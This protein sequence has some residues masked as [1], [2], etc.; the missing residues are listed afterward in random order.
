MKR[1]RLQYCLVLVLAMSNLALLAQNPFDAARLLT[2]SSAKIHPLKQPEKV[3]VPKKRFGRA[4]IQLGLAELIPFTFDRYVTRVD[5]AKISFKT[6][7]HNL[8]LSS[9][10]WDN[11]EFQ[12]NQF[13]HPYHG[14]L[15]FSSFRTNGYTFWE[16][17]PAVVVGSYLWE[18]FAENQEPSPNDFINTSFGGI[19]LGETTYRLSNKIINNRSRGFK[20]QASEV[21]AF[22]VNPMNGLT[23]IL[24]G[25]WGKVNHDPLAND[26]SK[27]SAEFDFGVR[28]Y[29]QSNENLS[30]KG[31]FGWY[32]RVKLLYGNAYEN[33]RTPFT[34]IYI[35][36]EFG[37]D[38]SSSVNIIN[39]YGSL[40]GWRIRSGEHIRHLAVLSA[41]YD[42]IRNQAFFYG[43]Q[44]VKLNLMSE[45]KL[46][47]GVK[48]NTL[49]G[50]GPVVLAAVPD[51][52][53]FRGRDYDYTSGIGVSGAGGFSIDE[54][55]F[56]SVNYRGGWLKTIN[57]NSSHYFLHTVSSEIRY[58]FLRGLSFTFE[59]GYFR[60]E[61]NYRD[62]EDVNKKYP[63]L[64]TSF[65][66][67]VNL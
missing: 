2:D 52:Y 26:S 16:S 18:T 42:Y 20:R 10:T 60:L 47:S 8:K 55:L 54:K 45:Y 6:I 58:E 33:Y 50:L 14:S 49:I 39:V 28:R 15:F 46:S 57:G 61:G 37:K 38:D 56:F 23:R 67:Q 9:W 25:K 51:K 5:Y 35:N 41:N 34:N 44:S 63:Y 13:G 19:V 30:T 36:A 32:G 24:D 62:Y 29:S 21:L 66:Y 11:D 22:I 27:V 59:P 4:M 43:A 1:K 65:R 3:V 7:G 17:A 48:M 40:A 31:R 64:R 53:R 12:T